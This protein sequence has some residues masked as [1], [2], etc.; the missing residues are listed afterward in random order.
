MPDSRNFR[1]VLQSI[2][3]L[4]IDTLPLQDLGLVL[5][6]ARVTT[7]ARFAIRASPA[8]MAPTG[9]IDRAKSSLIQLSPVSSSKPTVA[10]KSNKKDI[11]G[12]KLATAYQRSAAAFEHS[13]RLTLRR[14]LRNMY[15]QAPTVENSTT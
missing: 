15:T 5:I 4:S 6:I 1:S 14:S 2:G 9:I 12:R 13:R 7:K 10:R 3:C 11:K 8:A